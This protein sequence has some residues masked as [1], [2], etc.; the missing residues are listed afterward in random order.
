MSV[1]YAPILLLLLAPILRDLPLRD[2]LVVVAATIALTFA[3]W[4]FTFGVAW[5]RRAARL[6]RD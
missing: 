3:V 2:A 1:A 5:N 6:S 4:R